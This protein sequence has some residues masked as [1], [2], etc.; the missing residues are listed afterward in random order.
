MT[1]ISRLTLIAYCVGGW[2][3][4][5]THYHAH[6]DHGACHHVHCHVEAT[7]STATC[8]PI[9]RRSRV[10]DAAVI[11][12]NAKPLR[13]TRNSADRR[14]LLGGFT[15][16]S[17]QWVVCAMFGTLTDLNHT[18][19]NG[20]SVHVGRCHRKTSFDLETTLLSRSPASEHF[21]R[22]PPEIV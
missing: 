12:I 16:A 7:R 21:S 13:M 22:G 14:V 8:E 11:P 20:D 17:L 4:P 2:L 1:W 19:A 15:A 10:T 9:R 6:H 5:A 18:S 3:L